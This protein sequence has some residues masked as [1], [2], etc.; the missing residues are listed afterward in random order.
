MDAILQSILT[1]LM[2]RTLDEPSHGI[3][4]TGDGRLICESFLLG[5]H[6][7]SF[8]QALGIEC[9]PAALQYQQETEIRFGRQPVEQSRRVAPLTVGVPV[10]RDYP[11]R[12]VYQATGRKPMGTK[13]LYKKSDDDK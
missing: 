3:H 11:R 5:Q 4:M 13:Q 2:Q 10:R 1:R 12:E 6:V 7:C 8:L 9:Y